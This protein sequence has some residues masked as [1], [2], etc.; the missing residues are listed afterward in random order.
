MPDTLGIL[1]TSDRHLDHV[2]GVTD[3]AA[4]AGKKVTIFFTGESVR[5]TQRPEFA[6]LP[7]DAAVDLCEVSYRANGLE[8]DVPG[9]SY[10][11]F[12]TQA[13]DAE[14]MEDSGR[15]LVF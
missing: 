7:E 12:A 4:R 6:R 9:L 2:L 8:G 5:L 15:Y 1:V 10:K 11:N 3:A 13:K 14:M